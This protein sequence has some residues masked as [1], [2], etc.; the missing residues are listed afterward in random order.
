MNGTSRCLTN[1]LLPIYNSDVTTCSAIQDAG[2]NGLTSCNA[3]VEPDGSDF[4]GFVRDN[5]EQYEEVFSTS[6]MGRMIGMNEPG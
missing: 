5:K 4:C 6:D 2:A 1:R 3:R